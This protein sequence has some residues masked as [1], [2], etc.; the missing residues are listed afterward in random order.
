MPVIFDAPGERDGAGNPVFRAPNH[1][2]LSFAHPYFVAWPQPHSGTMNDT[3]IELRSGLSFSPH[4]ADQ[5]QVAKERDLE[6]AGRTLV[7]ARLVKDQPK[8]QCDNSFHLWLLGGNIQLLD[9]TDQLRYIADLV[10]A[11]NQF[12]QDAV[13]AVK[14][15]THAKSWNDFVNIIRANPGKQLSDLQRLFDASQT[16]PSGPFGIKPPHQPPKLP[17]IPP[18]PPLP[19]P[20]DCHKI[21]FGLPGSCQRAPSRIPHPRLP[22]H[23]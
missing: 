11:G 20:P 21:P 1:A 7:L 6:R 13:D 12:N 2:V 10:A 19:A 4:D 15:L 9:I 5:D 17:P 3:G 22:S 23:L 18:P 8:D 16:I 14:Q